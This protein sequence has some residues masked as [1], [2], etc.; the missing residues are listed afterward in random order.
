MY[1]LYSTYSGRLW[2]ATARYG[3]GHVDSRCGVRVLRD[4]RSQ[5]RTSAINGLL[6]FFAWEEERQNQFVL[7]SHHV[8]PR[9]NTLSKIPRLL[10][11]AFLGR[12]PSSFVISDSY[13]VPTFYLTLFLTHADCP[14]PA[15]LHR[16]PYFS[17]CYLPTTRRR[18]LYPDDDRT[19][20]SNLRN[21]LQA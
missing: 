9:Q 14:R 8:S 10:I 13:Q 4:E 18:F 19:R 16:T 5:P 12:I 7:L 2:Q 17:N 11:N 3:S 20:S 21:R 1:S 15:A 6:V